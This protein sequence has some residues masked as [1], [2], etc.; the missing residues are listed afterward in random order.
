MT[1]EKISLMNTVKG[2]IPAVEASYE[3]SRS[4]DG[5]SG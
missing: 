4:T 5:L 3:L 2:D 1:A